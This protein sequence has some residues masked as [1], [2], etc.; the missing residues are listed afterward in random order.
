MAKRRPEL[1]GFGRIF[2][3]LAKSEVNVGS[4][5]WV[6]PAGGAAQR[7]G[8]TQAERER[9]KRRLEVETTV[10]GQKDRSSGAETKRWDFG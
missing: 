7:S 2:R 5:A 3:D 10:G 9:P 8:G 1:K 4:G 6:P